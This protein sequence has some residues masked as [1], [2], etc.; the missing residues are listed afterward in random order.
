MNTRHPAILAVALTAVI[1][2]GCTAGHQIRKLP[3][4]LVPVD[5]A[6][7]YALPRTVITVAFP[8]EKTFTLEGTGKT[9]VGGAPAS[10]RSQLGDDISFWEKIPP[11]VDGRP[12]TMLA[13]IGLTKAPD[14]TKKA[15]KVKGSVKVGALAEPDPNQIFRVELGSSWA[16]KREL[17]LGFG[18][19]GVLESGTSSVQDRRVDLAVAFA[20]SVIPLLDFVRQENFGKVGIGINSEE[21]GRKGPKELLCGDVQGK[22]QQAACEIFRARAGL[23]RLPYRV[24]EENLDADQ[25]KWLSVRFDADIEKL[26]PVFVRPKKVT[27]EIVCALRPE[28][29]TKLN[30]PVEMLKLDPAAGFS[31]A[32]GTECLIPADF[33]GIG[34][35]PVTVFQAEIRVP[36]QFS[37]AMRKAKLD[38]AHDQD[39]DQ[40]FYYRI[41]AVAEIDVLKDDKRITT[42]Q[43][44]VAQ[45]GLVAALP[46]QS[47]YQTKYVVK[48][49]PATGALLSLTSN[50]EAIDPALITG[51]SDA[52]KGAL[53][54]RAEA[55]EK[56]AAAKDELAL[57]ERQRKLLEERDKIRELEKK[58]LEAGGS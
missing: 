48:L 14:P 30:A 4:P 43:Q 47:T 31:A 39:E 38:K 53:D 46:R 15:F 9:Q 33:E 55:K 28:E 37:E 6:A 17:T 41:P 13:A 52:I 45:L 35:G 21:F 2:G 51:T 57:L 49:D 50:S 12:K 25:A 5:Q 10:C 16:K 42:S 3:D 27:G 24:A 11:W 19:L 36:D 1:L 22:C 34:S 29:P 54:A 26:M 44:V 56:E 20:K 18:P 8:V 23:A 58:L 32:A 40:G 7:F